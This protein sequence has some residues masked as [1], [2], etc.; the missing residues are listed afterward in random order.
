VKI[1]IDNCLDTRVARL[2]DGHDVTHAWKQG[3]RDYGNGRLLAAAA[4]AGFE[5]VVTIDKNIRH[6]Q[7]LATLPT[8]VLELDVTSSRLGDVEG[9]AAFLGAAVRET[10]RYRF[11]SLKPGGLLERLSPRTVE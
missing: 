10:A 4:A 11:V 7:N 5:V 2:F 1:L 9:L 6:Q 3:W 8:S